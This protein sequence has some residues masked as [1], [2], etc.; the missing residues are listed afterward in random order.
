MKYDKKALTLEAEQI[1]D[2]IE[3]NKRVPLAS[4]LSTGQTLSPYSISYLFSIVAKDTL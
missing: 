1:K 4:T 3:K 2:Y